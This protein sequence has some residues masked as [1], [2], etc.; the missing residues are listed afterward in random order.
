MKV[1]Q[2][3]GIKDI[4]EFLYICRLRPIPLMN[5]DSLLAAAS[6]KSRLKLLPKDGSVAKVN[7]TGCRS[8]YDVWRLVITRRKVAWISDYRL[9]PHI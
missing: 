9:A 3:I 7:S 2:E 5:Q 8:A 6:R 4:L 1:H